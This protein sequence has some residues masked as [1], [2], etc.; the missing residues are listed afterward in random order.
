[1]NWKGYGRMKYSVIE[2]LSQ[3]LLEGTDKNHE[4][5]QIAFNL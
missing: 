4:N 1:M 2:V 3:H 5:L